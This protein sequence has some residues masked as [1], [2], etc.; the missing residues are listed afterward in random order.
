VWA[1]AGGGGGTWERR[2]VGEVEGVV[3][4][5][6]GGWVVIRDGGFVWLVGLMRLVGAAARDEDVLA[7]DE[8][9]GLDLETRGEAAGLAGAG[10]G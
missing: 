10:S 1:R 8:G 2:E 7:R 3:V 4:A 5:V 6:L 9:P